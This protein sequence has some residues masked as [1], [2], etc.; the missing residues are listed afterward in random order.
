M[1]G[2]T[3]LATLCCYGEGQSWR[4]NSIL[5]THF[6]D[7]RCVIPLNFIHQITEGLTGDV[8][9]YPSPARR[10]AAWMTAEQ[11]T[12]AIAWPCGALPCAVRCELVDRTDTVGWPSRLG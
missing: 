2:I 6:V 8:P 4:Q 1:V 11:M 12:L 7:D 9:A 10:I 3:L 5:V